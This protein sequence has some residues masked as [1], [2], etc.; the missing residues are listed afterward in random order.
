MTKVQGT[1]DFKDDKARKYLEKAVKGLAKYRVPE[2]AIVFSF[3]DLIIGMALE[4][5]KKIQKHNHYERCLKD[6]K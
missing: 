5:G 3:R 2:K 1:Y 6:I 4:C